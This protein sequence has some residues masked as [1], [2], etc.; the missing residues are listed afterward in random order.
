[1]NQLTLPYPLAHTKDPISSFKVGEEFH[2]SGKAEK[3]RIIIMNFLRTHNGST[4]HKIANNISLTQVQVMRRMSELRAKGE[5]IN[6]LNCQLNLHR[7]K[8]GDCAYPIF[9]N[10]EVTWWIK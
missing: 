3:H 2:K 8:G 6:C 1:M 4:G 9:K 5:V 7:C 10:N